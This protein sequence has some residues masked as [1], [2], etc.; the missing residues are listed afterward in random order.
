MSI[1][2]VIETK[3]TEQGKTQRELAELVGVSTSMIT[4]IERGTK[5]ISLPLAADLAKVFGCSLDDFVEG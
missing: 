2:K 3:R 4:Q 1:G 5:T